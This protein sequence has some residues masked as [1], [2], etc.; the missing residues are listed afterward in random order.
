[1]EKIRVARCCCG[2]LSLEILGEPKQIVACSCDYCQRR[3]GAIMQQSAWFTGHQIVSRAGEEKRY[4]APNN[5]GGGDYIFCPHCGSTVYWEMPNI[6]EVYGVELYGV[7]VGSFADPEF[8]RPKFEGWASK[9]HRWLG[10]VGVDAVYDEL[11]D[12]WPDLI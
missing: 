5:P 1:M 8:P 10:E 4:T 2:Q 6:G 12:K 11:P 9:R 7:A 3:T